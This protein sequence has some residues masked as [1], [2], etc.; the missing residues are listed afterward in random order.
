MTIWNADGQVRGVRQRVALWALLGALPL[1]QLAY[2]IAAK[3]AANVLA[4]VPF[5]SGWFL[6]LVH[7]P[8]AQGLLALEVAGFAAWMVVLAEIKLSAAFPLSAASYVL[9]VAA[10]WLLFREPLT[11]AQVV[12]GMAILAGAWLIASDGGAG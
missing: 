10:G 5:G 11:L 12:G 2:Q 3:Q 6:A 9:I 1:L 4:R 8:W 7:T